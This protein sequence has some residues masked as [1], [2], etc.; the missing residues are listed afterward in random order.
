VTIVGKGTGARH[1]AV[2]QVPA[3]SGEGGGYGSRSLLAAPKF[4]PRS[5]PRDCPGCKKQAMF[6]RATGHRRC[7]AV[8]IAAGRPEGTP[9]P[10]TPVRTVS[11]RIRYL[12]GYGI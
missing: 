10:W 12:N 3:K 5:Q 8:R 1:D 7:G 2:C 9:G 6:R 11:E 4:D